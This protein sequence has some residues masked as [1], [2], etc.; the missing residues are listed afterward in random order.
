MPSRVS[1]TLER[2]SLIFQSA[3]RSQEKPDI[4]REK[5]PVSDHGVAT[6]Y[7]VTTKFL[8]TFLCVPMTLSLRSQCVH[9][10]FTALHCADG[11][12]KAQ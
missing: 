10:A 5:R 4:F 9:S 12:L 8:L 7:R 6:F 3:V 1:T 2:S 11:V